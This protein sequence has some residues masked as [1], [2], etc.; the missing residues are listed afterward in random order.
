MDMYC[1]HLRVVE[2]R[3][4]RARARA[5]MCVHIHVVHAQYVHVG[6][7]MHIMLLCTYVCMHSGVEIEA[8]VNKGRCCWVP[9]LRSLLLFPKL[10]ASRSDA[11]SRESAAQQLS[12]VCVYT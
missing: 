1:G 3:G 4:A 11:A 12:I 9:R 2:A 7:H 5:Y 10:A 8:R 6:M